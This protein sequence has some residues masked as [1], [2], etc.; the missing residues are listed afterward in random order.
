MDAD[1]LFAAEAR[2]AVNLVQAPLVVVAGKRGTFVDVV[3]ASGSSESGQA[4]AAQVP[5]HYDA[6]TLVLARGTNGGGVG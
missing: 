6:G 5:A 3:L 4:V 1:V 2:V